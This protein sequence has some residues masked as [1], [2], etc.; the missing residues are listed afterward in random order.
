MRA[1]QERLSQIVRPLLPGFVSGRVTRRPGPWRIGCIS[2]Y[3]FSHSVMRCFEQVLKALAQ[4]PCELHALLAGPPV[5]D[6]TTAALQAVCRSWTPLRGPLTAQL[7]QIAALD[8]DLLLYTDTGLDPQTWLLSHYRLA[9]R[10]LLLPG[11]PLTSGVSTLDGFLSDR[12]SE[13]PGAQAHYSERLLLLPEPPTD[14]P[15][16]AWPSMG[17][18][19][20]STPLPGLPADHLYL[21]PGQ[22]FKLHPEMDT[23]LAGILAADPRA[24]I[25]LL[26][27]QPPALYRDLWARWQQSLGDDLTRVH[28]LPRQPAADFA[29]LLQQVAVV[30]ET[31]PFGSGNT[32]MAALAV[33]TPVVTWPGETL[34]GRYAQAFLQQLGVTDTVVTRAEDYIRCAVELATDPQ[35][36]AQ[37]SQRLLAGAGGLFDNPRI[38]PMVRQALLAEL[39]A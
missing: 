22:L 18:S 20:D 2:R 32:V 38:G 8:L 15:R 6:A 17:S 30:L 3:W 36:R 14:Y 28:L 27:Q 7:A 1:R 39:E 13:G 10:Q 31:R 4:P 5:H 12:V 9:P 29:R 35:R 19:A 16:P 34:C 26:Q 23:L 25:L 33:G 21:C 24:Q 11:Q 37:L